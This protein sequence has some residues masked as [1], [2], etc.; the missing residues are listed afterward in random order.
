[1]P[2]PGG[3]SAT[4]PFSPQMGIPLSEC[5]KGVSRPLRPRET[6][7]FRLVEE[8]RE[9]FGHVS[10]ER[11][12]DR[13]GF[14][15]PVVSETV[16]QYLGCG[17][18]R[19]SLTR[20]RYRDWRHEY[21]LAY[22]SYPAF[23]DGAVALQCY[24]PSSKRLECLLGVLCEGAFMR[25]FMPWSIPLP[26]PMPATSSHWCGS[27]SIGPPS[28]RRRGI[29]DSLRHF[30]VL[31][32]VLSLAP[33]CATVISGTSTNIQVT[34]IPPGAA[35][36]VQG[37]NKG[38][39]P[40]RVTVPIHS[41]QITVSHPQYKSLNK[42]F[43]KAMNPAMLLD[44]LFWPA[45]FVDLNSDARYSLSPRD[46]H[47]NLIAGTVG[48]LDEDRLRDDELYKATV[49]GNRLEGLLSYLKAYPNGR[50]AEEAKRILA[51]E[52]VPD[53]RAFERAVTENTVEAMLA[54]LQ[55]YPRG[56]HAEEARTWEGRHRDD[57]AFE[58][59]MSESTIE[60]MASYLKS[61]PR[62]LHLNEAQGELAFR[63]AVAGE[64]AGGKADLAAMVD[65]LKKHPDSRF[66][67]EA[68]RRIA[69]ILARFRI[70]PVKTLSLTVL[71]N[72]D[73]SIAPIPHL[74]SVQE[75]VGGRNVEVFAQSSAAA[76]AVVEIRVT[77]RGL[78]ASYGGAGDTGGKSYTSGASIE[79]TL[80]V[81]RKGMA[82]VIPFSNTIS[83]P[84]YLYL[85]G[86]AG[87]PFDL[88]WTGSTPYREAYGGAI[89]PSLA[90]MIELLFGDKDA[91]SPLPQTPPDNALQEKGVN[92]GA[93]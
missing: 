71:E 60:A 3:L 50:H 93:R 38:T 43:D 70:P 81:S 91:F 83:P 35:I 82:Y 2:S 37:A 74:A 85:S 21:L 48:T 64:R 27:G 42:T 52:R 47:F 63:R 61:F 31:V 72:G 51:V 1:M 78:A 17:D 53:D 45:F 18:L 44:I 77:A 4:R 10:P 46:V 22:W 13:Y 14:F 7:F 54:Y 55:E 26:R 6:A 19:Q 59:A 86:A 41:P 90:T 67:E 40:A 68:R 32:A 8:R 73:K 62:G 24:T 39:T 75:A 12:E 92:R 9:R 58:Q 11:Y 57:Q 16:Y 34:S 80:T 69:G 28:Q 65:H 87:S 36:M 84:Q 30:A 29:R 5:A 88:R 25:K 49:S 15:R 66:V 20:V 76:D 56:L 23:V 79:G 33:G 89:A